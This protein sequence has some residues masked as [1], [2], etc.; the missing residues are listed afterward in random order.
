MTQRELVR[1]ALR[2]EHL[3]RYPCGPLA[4][5]STAWLAGVP[6][7]DYTLDPQCMADCIVAYWERFRPDAVWVS[8]DT[9]VTAQA[10]GAEVA[11]PG[12]NQ[13]LTGTGRPLIEEPADLDAIPPADPDRQGRMPLIAEAL[14]MVRRRLGED[15]FIV[16]CFDQSPFSLACA[17]AGLGRV[18]TLLFDD[19]GFVR[20]LLART[21]E[22][23]I[24]Y[25]CALAKAG[26]DLLSTGDSPAGL[27]GPD[28]YR[29][30]AL[31][32][33]QR[34]FQA[35]RAACSIPCSLHICGN[36]SHLL[37]DMSRSGA[38]VLELDSAVLIE[39]ACEKVPKEIAI[40]GNLDP[41]GLLRDG[42][43]AQVEEAVVRTLGVCRRLERRRFVLSSGCTLCPDTPPAN[44]EA[45]FRAG[46][47]VSQ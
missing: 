18:C 44:L 27:L 15:V 26:A 31:P 4:V 17:V 36:T 43:P 16:G 13:P 2:G 38:Q 45:L 40:W 32:A 34:V 9:W 20:A 30:F 21:T 37:Q 5:H 8:A 22:Y 25:A 46:R 19:P 28:H 29:E 41:V 3:H 33:Q 23:C 6:I 42:T 11:F 10:M 7:R 1:A 12:E 24:A 35:V 14:R 47:R 39:M